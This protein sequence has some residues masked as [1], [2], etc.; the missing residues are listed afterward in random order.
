MNDKWKDFWRGVLAIFLSILTAGV[1][2]LIRRSRAV[3]DSHAP[4]EDAK[5]AQEEIDAS[6]A[7]IHADSNQAL[8]DRFNTLA[9]K[10]ESK[11]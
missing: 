3:P 10:E 2:L 8:A 1:Y 11:P 7:A 5:I 4:V 6:R 9:K